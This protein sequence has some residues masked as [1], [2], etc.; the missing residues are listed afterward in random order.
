MAKDSAMHNFMSLR[1]DMSDKMI[2][3][4]HYPFVLRTHLHWTDDAERCNRMRID[5]T[6]H[7]I[8]FLVL[9]DDPVIIGFRSQEDLNLYKMLGKIERKTFNMYGIDMRG[10]AIE[11]HMVDYYEFVG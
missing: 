11:P 10:N 1:D 3:D 7:G 2:I 4:P 5:I 8:K 9:K 6:S